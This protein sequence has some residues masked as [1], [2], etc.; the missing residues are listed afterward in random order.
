MA[1]LCVSTLVQWIK[2]E[3]YHQ[4]HDISKWW[5]KIK[6]LSLIDIQNNVVNNVYDRII[7]NCVDYKGGGVFGHQ[8]FSLVS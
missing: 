6:I 7:Y 8:V 2:I 5:S 4:F 3:V 1:N